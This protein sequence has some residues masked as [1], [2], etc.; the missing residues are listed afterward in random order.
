M[1]VTTRALAAY[2]WD[3]TSGLAIAGGGIIGGYVR[4][5]IKRNKAYAESVEP[6]AKEWSPVLVA[7][8]IA[9]AYSI[10]RPRMP[11]IPDFVDR[12]VVGIVSGLAARTGD[13]LAGDTEIFVSGKMKLVAKNV[14][15]VSKVIVDGT[16]V[17]QNVTINGDEIDL[18][19]AGITPGVHKVI[20]IGVDKAAYEE[21]YIPG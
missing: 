19:N 16:D 9:V 18:S 20:V 17:T 12:L 6:V 5:W 21:L 4:K 11:N 2:G 7:A 13:I 15:N 3:V 14:G 8:G 1:A 10:L